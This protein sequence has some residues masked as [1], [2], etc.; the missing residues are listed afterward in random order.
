MMINI[1]LT[2][3]TIFSLSGIKSEQIDELKKKE[4]N[5][6]YFLNQ[7]NLWIAHCNLFIWK[8]ISND[9]PQTNHIL[10]WFSIRLLIWILLCSEYAFVYFHFHCRKNIH[11]ICWNASANRNQTIVCAEYIFVVNDSKIL[12][13]LLAFCVWWF[14]YCDHQLLNGAREMYL[15]AG[16]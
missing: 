10:L 7:I 4:I 9:F 12:A 3:T 16:K 11:W 15:S 13:I 6:I 14:F 5:I 8:Q 2:H 1:Y